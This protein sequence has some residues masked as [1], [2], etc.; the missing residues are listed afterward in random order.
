MMNR[1]LHDNVAGVF[2]VCV[3]AI[4]VGMWWYFNKR[5]SVATVVDEP[6]VEQV[7]PNEA[8]RRAQRQRYLR[9]TYQNTGRLPKDNEGPYQSR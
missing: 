6:T 5:T 7:D 1:K 2:F 3:V 4:V 9:E 8:H